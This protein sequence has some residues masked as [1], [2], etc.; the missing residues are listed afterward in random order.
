MDRASNWSEHQAITGPHMEVPVSCGLEH[1]SMRRAAEVH[2]DE[3]SDSRAGTRI[4]ERRHLLKDCHSEE[5][6]AV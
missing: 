5:G 3:K 1:G 6:S 4:A 2:G